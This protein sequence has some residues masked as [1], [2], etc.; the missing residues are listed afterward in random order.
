MSTMY[1]QEC[2]TEI[3]RKAKM[4]PKC[5]I[6]VKYKGPLSVLRL[7]IGVL[8]LVFSLFIIF[9][10]MAAGIVNTLEDTGDVGGSAGVLV[11][12]LF[13]AAGIAGIATRNSRKKV[14]PII[15]FVLYVFSGLLGFSNSAVYSDLQI[16]GGLAIIFGIIFLI[17]GLRTKNEKK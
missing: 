10:S 14:G 2:G 9:Q 15:C 6:P 11:A 4:C 16:W 12:T 17:A 13:I 5:G 1:C 7:V 8:S 3:S